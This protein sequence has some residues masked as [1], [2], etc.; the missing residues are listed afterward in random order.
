MN[1]LKI[2]GI[3]K[4]FKGKLYIVEDVAFHSETYG[5]TP[6]KYLRSLGFNVNNDIFA[7]NSW[8]FR[9]AL[10]RA[11]YNNLQSIINQR[12]T[13]MKLLIVIDMQNHAKSPN[14]MYVSM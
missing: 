13:K 10:V 8:Y 9:N 6:S 2:H 3:Y 5:L 14:A 1:T 7:E 4:H 12:A 11:N